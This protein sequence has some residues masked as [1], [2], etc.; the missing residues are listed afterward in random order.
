VKPMARTSE[1]LKLRAIEYLTFDRNLPCAMMARMLKDWVRESGSNL[2][3]PSETTCWRFINEYQ[4]RTSDRWTV[5]GASV[6]ELVSIVYIY[7]FLNT[8]VTPDVWVSKGQMA[9]FTKIRLAFPAMGHRICYLIST[10]YAVNHLSE[11][12]FIEWLQ[13]EDERGK[14]PQP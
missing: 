11:S 1:E 2:E 3:T 10:A 6:D 9:W 12:G 13:G 7:R 14:E 8:P 5:D 4:E